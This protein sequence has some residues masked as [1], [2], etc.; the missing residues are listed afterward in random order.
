MH[1]GY[2]L[3]DLLKNL[4]FQIL[5][6]AAADAMLLID[7]SMHIAAANPVARKV[8]A[9]DHAE[10]VDLE[11]SALIPLRY[12]EFYL[13][14]YAEFYGTPHVQTMGTELIAR[15]NDN[16]ELL[17]NIKLSRVQIA[18]QLYILAIFN[19]ADRRN[20]VTAALRAS[21]ERLRLAKQ[22]A[23]LGVFDFDS[24]H[25]MMHWDER[26]RELWGAESDKLVTYKRFVTAIHPEDRAAR[27]AALNSAIDPQGN[28]EYNAE[29]RVMNPVDG[30]ERWVATVGRMHFED[31]HAT[32]LV[33]VAR[34]ITE[35]KDLE[36]KL[37]DHR[38]ESETLFTQQVAAQTVSAIAHE[39]N[40]PLAAISAYSEVALHELQSDHIDPDKLQHALQGCA[41][42][43]QR[44]GSSLHELLA[45]LQKGQLDTESMDFSQVVKEALNI[46]KSYGYSGFSPIL[47]LEQNMPPIVGNRIQIVK[48][49]VN[50]LRNA[51]EAMHAAA[52]SPPTITIKV[53]TNRDKNMAHTTVEDSG[54]GIDHQ[55]A[56]RI[57]E[58][59][60]TTKASGIGMGL[61]ISRALIEANG[62]QLWLELSAKPKAVFHFTLP[63]AVSI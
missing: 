24:N 45:L 47:Q 17:I 35:Q 62:G 52:S 14:Q 13:C 48:V 9:Y 53:K 8:L 55:T 58:P 27:L 32:R 28:G 33:G 16:K 7:P 5:F 51:M 39:L 41:T 19:L 44:A 15:S 54:P 40:Q 12:Q 56:R 11:I 1:K 22:A 6:D 34:D 46:T 29:Y 59:F 63:F 37:Q 3:T 43:A 20:K 61:A 36:K 42:Q 23:G 2:C 25:N 26:M 60:F 30:V 4:S 21:E 38:S 31:G 57:F 49:L 50:L 10:I 18:Q